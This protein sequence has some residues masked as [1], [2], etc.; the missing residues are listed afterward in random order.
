MKRPRAGYLG[1]CT[2]RVG[3]GRGLTAR[4]A[5]CVI[6]ILAVSGL[7]V[8]CF[9]RFFAG[10]LAYPCVGVSTL[11]LLVPTVELFRG[12]KVKA[13]SWVTRGLH[14]EGLA[15]GGDSRSEEHTSELQ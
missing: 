2:Q 3:G 1:A 13:P 7:F 9:L 14:S 4:D 10:V 11:V 8:Q 6:S 12:E 5:V 15:V